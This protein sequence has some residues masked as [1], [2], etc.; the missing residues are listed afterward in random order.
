MMSSM[1]D[2]QRCA[3]C[4]EEKPTNAFVWD[5]HNTHICKACETFL[6]SQCSASKPFMGYS[7]KQLDKDDKR[8]CKA[9][10]GQCT[11]TLYCT[12]C[13]RESNITCFHKTYRSPPVCN[14]CLEAIRLGEEED[15]LGYTGNYVG[16]GEYD[17]SSG[18]EDGSG[19]Y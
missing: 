14:K 15:I 4:D 5:T 16:H 10:T 18:M 6:C 11:D 19:M 3:R 13:D 7:R 1:S 8:K 17:T 2:T 9:C 12:Q